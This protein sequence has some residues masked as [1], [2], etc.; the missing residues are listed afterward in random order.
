[1]APSAE[2]PVFNFTC[3]EPQQQ[4]LPL[5]GI[6]VPARVSHHPTLSW[7]HPSPPPAWVCYHL[8]LMAGKP[9]RPQPLQQEHSS[10]PLLKTS[11]KPPLTDICVK[12]CVYCMTP[13]ALD[14]TAWGLG[15]QC[16]PT[17]PVSICSCL[18]LSRAA[19]DQAAPYLGSKKCQPPQVRTRCPDSSSVGPQTLAQLGAFPSLSPHFPLPSSITWGAATA[20]YDCW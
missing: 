11:A 3:K 6:Q 2:S 15:W 4:R 17:V 19:P 18:K 14:P 13:K 9:C 12:S 1:M 16:Q 10:Q 5:R 7:A 20:F 8:Q